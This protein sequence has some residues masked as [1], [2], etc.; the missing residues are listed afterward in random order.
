MGRPLGQALVADRRHG[1]NE[2]W[3][4]Q[5]GNLRAAKGFPVTG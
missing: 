4:V 1:A 2:F 3:A 5:P